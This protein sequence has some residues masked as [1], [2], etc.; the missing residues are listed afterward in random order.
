MAT[1]LDPEHPPQPINTRGQKGVS[2]YSLNCFTIDLLIIDLYMCH[3][4]YRQQNTSVHHV[5]ING[6]SGT[7][8]GVQRLVNAVVKHGFHLM[9]S[10]PMKLQR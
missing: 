8:E 6:R 9:T 5:E 2:C 7:P 10:C 1:P 4:A 3:S